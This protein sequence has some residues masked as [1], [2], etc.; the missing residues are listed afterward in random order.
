MALPLTGASAAPDLYR[1]WRR[2]GR[3]PVR[4]LGDDMPS[5]I[6]VNCKLYQWFAGREW[7]RWERND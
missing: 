5:E 3:G 6:H 2:R 7:N 4:R 1:A